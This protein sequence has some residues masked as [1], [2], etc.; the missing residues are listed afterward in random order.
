MPEGHSIRFMGNLHR[1]AFSNK[2]LTI[3]SPQGRFTEGAAKIDQKQLTDVTTHGKHL[4][5]HFADDIVHIHLGLYGWFEL[6]KNP[7]QQP[8]DSIRMRIQTENDD[9]MTY[10]S[11]L[12]GPTVCKLVSKEE[13]E[14]KRLKLG[15]DPLREDANPELAWEAIHKSKRTIGELLMDQSVFAG[16]GNVYRAE[17]LFL[18]RLNPYISGNSL[19][20][21]T[22]NE[23]W[24]NAKTLLAEGSIDGSI[25]TVKQKHLQPNECSQTGCAQTSYVYKRHGQNCRVCN[26][27][28]K[29]N[30]LKARMLYWCNNC[31]VKID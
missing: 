4:F 6:S 19:S 14:A 26:N 22:F 7:K 23:I 15:A 27:I 8:K 31:Q 24:N 2:T 12:V 1:S 17:L 25:R 18:S 16:I 11:D 30:E 5:L 13:M 9:G 21:S 28:I 20:K 3:T 29:M 10:V